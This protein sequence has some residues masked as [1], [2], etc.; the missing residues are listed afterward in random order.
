MSETLINISRKQAYLFSAFLVFFEF[1]TYVSNDM[2]MPAMLTITQDFH[3]EATYVASSLS[4]Y[5]IGG[6]SLQLMIGPL[7]D[8]YGRRPVMLIGGLLFFCFTLL[9]GLSQTMTQFMIGRVFQG[10]GM[11]FLIIGYAAIQEMFEEMDAVRLIAIMANTSIIAP[12]LGPLLGAYLILHMPWR[13]MY[14]LIAIA[15]FFVLLGLFKTTPETIG[16]KKRVL[17]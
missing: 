15:T 16:V 10:M 6:A 2:I 17:S 3:A 12:L 11:C 1:L 9:L 14:Y 8:V 4:A 13:I 7:S 5:M